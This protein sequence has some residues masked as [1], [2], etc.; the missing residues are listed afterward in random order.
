[1]MSDDAVNGAATHFTETILWRTVRA[2]NLSGIC[3]RFL[4]LAILARCGFM[5]LGSLSDNERD[6]TI[7]IDVAV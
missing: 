7:M 1:M 4:L 5:D 2:K 3:F 6:A